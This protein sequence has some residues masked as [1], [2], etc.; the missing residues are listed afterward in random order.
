MGFAGSI[1][2]TFDKPEVKPT[3]QWLAPIF[4]V[5]AIASVSVSLLRRD[6]D[7]R[8]IQIANLVGYA[9]GFGVV[10]IA[11][12]AVF[13]TVQSLVAAYLCQAVLTLILL[14][15]KTR[16]SIGFT[17]ETIDRSVF[18]GFGANILVTNL[19]NWAAS[20]LD[21]LIVSRLFSS[22]TLGYYSASFNLIY[23]PVGALYASLQ[24][25]V[26][27]SVARMQDEL[28]RMRAAYL[29]LLRTVT[30]AFLPMFIGLYFYSGP[31][32]LAIY[33]EQWVAAAPIA[34]PFCLMAPFVM[35]W[36]C[37]TPVL[38]NT[39]RNSLEWK[40][41]LP[42]LALT[43]LVIVP[44]ASSSIVAVA[45]AASGIYMTRTI[46]MMGLACRAL[47]ISFIQVFA[48]VWPGIWIAAIVCVV[49]QACALQLQANVIP[50][51][52]QV[53]L[54]ALVVLATIVTC[55]LSVPA[56][57]PEVVRGYIGNLIPLAP[58]LLRPLL[59]RLNR[60]P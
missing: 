50:V 21:R 46:L 51:A 38:W 17:L 27:S 30:L 10:G 2:S 24:S 9:L 49:A 23:S 35:I 36:A 32:V 58:Q 48:A 47:G 45:W 3:L 19:V 44:A 13:G 29:L 53:V 6:L 28:L 18:L 20:S 25:T 37:S 42:F 43:V 8:S 34:G 5:N 60:T 11:A 31:L 22:A 1:A 33:G 56:V 4:V 7:Y 12:A 40:V 39:G 14:Y 16:H 54:G 52:L 15:R 57:L 41:Q 55:L 26:F 59:N